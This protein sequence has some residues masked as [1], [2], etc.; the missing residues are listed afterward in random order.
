MK[1]DE[2]LWETKMLT[3]QSSVILYC[4]VWQVGANVI[5]PLSEAGGSYR[6]SPERRHTVD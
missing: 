2:S 4:I 1:P 3:S 5:V 6:V